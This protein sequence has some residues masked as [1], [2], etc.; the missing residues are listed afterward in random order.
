MTTGFGSQVIAVVER[1]LARERRRGDVL[2]VTIPFGA[3]ALLLL[4]LAVGTDSVLLQR[5]GP[6][7]YWVTVMLFGV[8][9]SVGRATVDTPA[10]RDA[11]ALLGLDPAAGYVGRSTS[12]AGLLIVYE[13]VVGSVAVVLYGFELVG[14][15]WLIVTLILV[16]AGLGLLGS[17]A[18]SLVGSSSA[19]SALVP[20]LVAPLSVPLLLG[21]TQAY[22]GLRSGNSILPWMLLMAAVVLAAAIV[23]VLTARPLQE[24]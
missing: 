23:G 18:A 19:G 2:W 15:P 16:A 7:V 14:I 5:I 3:M 21:A 10:Q 1:D 24:T 9:V 11:A 6:G 4:P 20:L 17:L 22:E 8:L 13:I 12:A